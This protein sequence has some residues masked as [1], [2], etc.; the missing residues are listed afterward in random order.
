V[1]LKVQDKGDEVLFA[2]KDQGPGIL[3]ADLPHLF[4]IYYRGA[5]AGKERGFGLGLATVKR[6][7]E[8]HGGRLWVESQPGKG[9]TFY[10]TLL[11]E[12]AS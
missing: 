10:F 8:V 7:I 4:E 9:S 1:I 2:I 5:E 12:S 11:R 3:P 6:I